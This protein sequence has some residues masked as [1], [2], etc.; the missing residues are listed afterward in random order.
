MHKLLT[1]YFRCSDLP[2]DFS[3]ASPL[4]ENPG[5]FSFGPEIPC[6][7]RSSRSVAPTLSN[8]HDVYADTQLNGSV[9]DLPFDPAE[10]IDN[11]LYE[12]YLPPRNEYKQGIKNAIREAYYWIRP[13]LP[14]PVRK[15]LQKVHLS[16]WQHLP[17]PRW[18]VD[19]TVDALHE[20]LLTLSIASAEVEA[21]PFIWF[22]PEGAT[23]AA[24]VTHDVETD[25][26]VQL[27]SYVMDIDESHGIYSSFQIV[28]RQ[29]YEVTQKYLS[30]LRARGFEVNVHD[31]NH[32]GRL[33]RSWTDF[34]QRVVEI[35][36][37][38]REFGA[39]GF[40][41]AVLYRHQDWYDLLEFEYD[42]SVP[43]VAHLDP[44]RGGCCTVMPYFVG[45]ILELP[46]TMTQDY[47]LFYILNDYSLTLWNRQIDLILQKHGLLSVIVHP[48]YL[49]GGRA[50]MTYRELLTLLAQLKQSQNVWV[51]LPREVNKW[52][53]QRSK[54]E[55]VCRN[56][57][58]QVEG[59]GSERARIALAHIDG[60]RLTY[61]IQPQASRI[62]RGQP[63]LLTGREELS[64]K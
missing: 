20:Q 47:S 15:H 5:Y 2:A 21:I 18:P 37:H 45:N 17:F 50:T 61:A 42:M 40:R 22:W 32:D 55:L 1:E 51:T 44:Q 9:I 56:R 36:R 54:M 52:W 38:G 41:S 28:P 10:V 24:I 12:R 16:G 46:V 13:L 11:L 30:S 23:A 59:A 29:R 35:N 62:A 33:F 64:E 4:S 63:T 6:Y 26:G 19:T 25:K 39:V 53:R 49:G 48:D 8:A 14:V 27:S 43:N 7:G 34:K 3:V 57:R 60:G 31:L 58:W